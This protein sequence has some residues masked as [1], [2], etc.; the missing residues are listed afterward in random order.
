MISVTSSQLERIKPPM[1]R[2]LLYE[3]ALALF[4]T[5]LAQ[6]STGAMLWR[7]S[8][9]SLSSGLRIFGYLRRLAL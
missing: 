5:M 1:P 3:S 9:H 2:L 4:S 8:R 6:A 7:A